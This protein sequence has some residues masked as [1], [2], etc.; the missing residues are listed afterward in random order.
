LR[1]TIL[2]CNLLAKSGSLFCHACEKYPCARLK[3]LDKRYRTKYR[4]SLLGNLEYLRQNGPEA[5]L[6]Q[7]DDAW[8]C[9]DCGENICVHRGYCLKCGPK[10]AGS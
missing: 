7:Q 9:R 4:L 2:N 3:S 10:P 1:C 5:F 8:H 6:Q